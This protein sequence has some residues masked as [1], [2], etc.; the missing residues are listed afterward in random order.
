MIRLIRRPEW[1]RN[2]ME[3]KMRKE[4]TNEKWHHYVMTLASS[5]KS[6]SLIVPSFTILT[7]TS[8]LPLHLPRRTTPN[9]PDPNSSSSVSS[10]GSISHLSWLNPAVAGIDLSPQG[11][12]FNRHAKPPLLCLRQ[13]K[14]THKTKWIKQKHNCTE[15]LQTKY[16]TYLLQKKLRIKLCKNERFKYI[17]NDNTWINF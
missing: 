5:I 12:T 1:N 4:T 15:K 16:M 7:A 9:W 10:E 6:S 8:I 2:R 17:I 3:R 13:P 11:G 14:H